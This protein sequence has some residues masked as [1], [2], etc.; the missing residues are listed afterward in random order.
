VTDAPET[1]VPLRDGSLVGLKTPRGLVVAGPYYRAGRVERVAEVA[2]GRLLQGEDQV[3]IFWLKPVG[4]LD[5]RISGRPHRIAFTCANPNPDPVSVSWS[6]EG[7]VMPGRFSADPVAAVRL[8]HV[9]K[10][11]AS[12]GTFALATREQ[13]ALLRMKLGRGSAGSATLPA[14]V[15]I[16]I[17]GDSY[18]RLVGGEVFLVAEK[19]FA[20]SQLLLLLFVA[21]CLALG[22]WLVGRRLLKRAP[23]ATS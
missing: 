4:S 3:P 16:P 1:I 6:L 15:K 13:V 8:S 7:L 9:C 20:W 17:G 11:G 14:E 5:P 22:S 2:K 10:P 21:T 18:L 12:G 19:Y 23:S